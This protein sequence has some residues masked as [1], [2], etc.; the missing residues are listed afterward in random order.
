MKV[1]YIYSGTRKKLVGEPG[2]DY[3]DTS[4]YG[5]NHLG[6]F[7][8]E[9]EY[10]EFSDLPLIGALPMPSFALRHALTTL[11]FSLSGKYDLIFGSSLLYGLFLKKLF[12]LK[13]KMALLDISLGR[14]LSAN[15]KSRFKTILLKSALRQASAIVCLSDYQKRF[16]EKECP[17]LKD[18]IKVV[19]LGVDV[20]YYRPVYEGRSGYFLSAGRDNGRDYR[21]VFKIAALLPQ[22]QFELVAS[23]RNVKG[24]GEAP[25]NLKLYFDLPHAEWRKKFNEARMLLLITHPDGFEDGS[26]CSGQTALLEAFASGL[27]VVA[28]RKGYISEYGQEEEDLV[29]VEPYDEKA[30]AGQIANLPQDKL[31]SMARAARERV[32]KE[33]S[34]KRMAE[35]LSKI[36]LNLA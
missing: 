4:L 31:K 22:E 26:D 1:L 2:Q 16:L 20:D 33:F 10:K 24:L 34:T 29:L 17:E 5:E 8:I 27:P 28:T 35:N 14:T 18:E 7:G 6:A 30:L 32:E 11:Y 21:T 19:P 15:R 3:P 23:P 12:G 9:A 36:F 13:Q 25:Q